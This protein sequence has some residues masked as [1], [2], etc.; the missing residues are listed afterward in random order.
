M[1]E[2]HQHVTV[3]AKYLTESKYNY[4]VFSVLKPKLQF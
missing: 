2:N 1:F 4:L 3:S